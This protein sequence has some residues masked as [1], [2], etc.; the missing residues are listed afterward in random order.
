[1]RTCPHNNN[2]DHRSHLVLH[3]DDRRDAEH[4]ALFGGDAYGATAAPDEPGANYE[5][6]AC[7]L[8]MPKMLTMLAMP[9]VQDLGLP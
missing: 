8:L 2:E 9:T 6:V 1:M 7:R 3:M 4:E 5:G